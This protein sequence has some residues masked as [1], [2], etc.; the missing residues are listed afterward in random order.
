M[1]E[2]PSVSG[3]EPS[4][5]ESSSLLYVYVRPEVHGSEVHASE[6]NAYIV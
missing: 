6:V 2:Y 4:P 3:T 1:Y 5:R